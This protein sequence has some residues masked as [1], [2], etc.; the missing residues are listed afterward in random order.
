MLSRDW[1]GFSKPWVAF[2]AGMHT[3]SV[4][5]K[6]TST[7]MRS[8][9]WAI[10]NRHFSI[11]FDF[12]H[13]FSIKLEDVSLRINM[14]FLKTLPAQA[15]KSTENSVFRSLNN[16]NTWPLII[17][18][19]VENFDIETIPSGSEAKTWSGVV[20]FIKW[21]KILFHICIQDC[22]ISYWIGC[23]RFGI[24]RRE[25]SHHIAIFISRDLDS[26]LNIEDSSS[27]VIECGNL[28]SSGI[29]NKIELFCHRI[30]F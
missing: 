30:P 4:N 1:I 23:F 17:T 10:I 13:L 19:F 5:T 22:R 6:V 24:T 18:Q 29:I 26:T 11:I 2:F 7:E 8:I 9:C 27:N 16:W 20:I 12:H 21:L 25:W 3:L 15:S 28:D 14:I